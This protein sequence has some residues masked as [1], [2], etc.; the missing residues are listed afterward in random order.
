M[1]T[2]PSRSIILIEN[3]LCGNLSMAKG[4]GLTVGQMKWAVPSAVRAEVGADVWKAALKAVMVSVPLDRFYTGVALS[5]VTT[6]GRLVDAG[7]NEEFI[8]LVDEIRE[9][10]A[11]ARASRVLAHL[12]QNG[13]EGSPVWF[14]P[15]KEW[16]ASKFDLVIA[17]HLMHEFFNTHPDFRVS[18]K[19]FPAINRGWKV[20]K[21]NKDDLPLFREVYAEDET[22]FRRLMVYSPRPE[23]VRLIYGYCATCV[24]PAKPELAP[25]DLT[26]KDEE[27]SEP[28]PVVEV[29]EYS[30]E[31]GSEVAEDAPDEESGDQGPKTKKKRRLS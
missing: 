28:I 9:E 14:R 12:K 20:A 31:S 26:S 18:V 10:S 17:T 19:F 13:F 24:A 6:E 29:A 8:A 30:P 3:P 22:L 7:A 11:E 2:N 16:L 15:Q 21:L 27:V 4:M 25:I 5:V 1:K 23:K